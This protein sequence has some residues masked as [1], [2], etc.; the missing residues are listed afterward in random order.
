M[1]SFFA[2]FLFS[3]L[4]SQVSFAQLAEVE[5]S[6]SSATIT[7]SSDALIKEAGIKM[8]KMVFVGGS[9]NLM[10][11]EA[12]AVNVT[13]IS[14][15]LSE[16]DIIPQT[17]EQAM[18]SAGIIFPACGEVELYASLNVKD[19]AYNLKLNGVQQA[20]LMVTGNTV[21]VVK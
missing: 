8:L 14:E 19:G 11:F 18:E 15:D 1:K 21:Q 10:Q 7:E 12:Q 4:I 3:T 6:F 17:N 16:I 13:K 9:C 5:W 2:L 20:A